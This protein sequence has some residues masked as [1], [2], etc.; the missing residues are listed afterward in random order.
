MFSIE[1]SGLEDTIDERI[2]LSWDIANE[3]AGCGL[4]DDKTGRLVSP[5]NYHTDKGT[6]LGII[7]RQQQQIDEMRIHLELWKKQV[8][9]LKNISNKEV[10]FYFLQGYDLQEVEQ[11]SVID[12]DG[13]TEITFKLTNTDEGGNPKE[14]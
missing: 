8:E 9:L 5:M 1:V 6:Y 10:I 2:E 13:R 4:L 11:E 7:Q 12:V 3:Y 14:E